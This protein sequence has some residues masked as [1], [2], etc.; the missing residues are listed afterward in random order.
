MAKGW[1]AKDRDTKDV[2]DVIPKTNG[3]LWKALLALEGRLPER[4]SR[5]THEGHE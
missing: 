3:I 2:I 1:S 4:P 5:R